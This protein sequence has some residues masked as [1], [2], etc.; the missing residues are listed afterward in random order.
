MSRERSRTPSPNKQKN[1]ERGAFSSLSTV[2]FLRSSLEERKPNPTTSINQATT[3]LRN[4]MSGRFRSSGHSR[5]AESPSPAR[6]ATPE[7]PARDTNFRSPKRLSNG[8][9]KT[10]PEVKPFSVKSKPDE[11]SAKLTETIKKLNLVLAKEK[12]KSSKFEQ[13]LSSLKQKMAENADL[14]A[15]NSKLKQQIQKLKFSFSNVE[16]ERDRYLK[17][18]KSAAAQIDYFKNSLK[19]MTEM[20]VGILGALVEKDCYSLETSLEASMDNIEEEFRYTLIQNIQTKL[21]KMIETMAKE[22]SLDL[23]K[24]QRAV[25]VWAVKSLHNLP[26]QKKEPVQSPQFKL[27]KQ[28]NN[29]LSYHVEYFT[30]E[31]SIDITPKTFAPDGFVASTPADRL[32]RIEIDDSAKV[33][34]SFADAEFA[35][36]LYDFEG[37]REGDLNFK[38]GEGM[39]IS[40]KHDSGWWIGRLKEQ[41]GVFPYN[42]VESL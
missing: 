20:M 8:M 22:T 2:A 26:M 15:Q 36:A 17:D 12:Q 40:D 30:D 31:D 35:I 9:I 38:R 25:S 37:E 4:T 1:M 24:E 13:E 11:E 7:R 34:M 19:G 18:L 27:T 23:S 6:K 39:D 21:K 28:E 10:E 16:I 41:T 42:F 32:N 29:G 5:P 33:E 3:V 14:E